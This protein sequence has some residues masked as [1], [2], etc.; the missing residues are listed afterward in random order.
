MSGSKQSGTT[1]QAEDQANSLP[2]ERRTYLRSLA[3]GAAVSGGAAGG[4]AAAEQSSGSQD[5][6]ESSTDH[7][8]CDGGVGYGCVPYGL[9][10]YG[11]GPPALP[12]IDI[13]PIDH[14]DDGKFEDLDGDGQADIFDVQALYAHQDETIVSDYYA[15]YDF[16]DSQD[17][18]LD[19]LDIQGLFNLVT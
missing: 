19:I 3:A 18:D 15:V 8:D 7:N 2:V 11:G 1:G 4:T 10:R 17:G 13:P 6:V 16:D 14:D 5:E 12:G 9:G